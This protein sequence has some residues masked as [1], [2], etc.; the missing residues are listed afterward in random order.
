[1]IT[2][3][4][5]DVDSGGQIFHVQTEDK[6]CSNPI[7]ETLVYT[8][9]E[10]VCAR[11][12]SY[13]ELVAAGGC[14]E[15]PIQQLMETQHRELIRQIREGRLSKEDLQPFGGSVVSNRSFDEVVRVFLERCVPIERIRLEVLEPQRV[16]AGERATIRLLVTE[17]T[18]ERP[19]CGASVVFRLLGR[20]G[21]A[22]ELSSAQTDEAGR[23]E[24][25]CEIGQRP[26]A[27]AVL[28]CEVNV[29]GQAAEVRC[30][31]SSPAS[32]RPA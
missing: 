30:P 5:T 26:G 15:G 11:K 13:S 14:S 16:C 27:G 6:G 20:N 17:E 24:A 7:I 18:S 22:T 4:N 3:F 10:I 31:V 29:A 23:V 12:T 32:P 9:G 28:V 2:G 8:G 1:M 21:A 25:L 19:L